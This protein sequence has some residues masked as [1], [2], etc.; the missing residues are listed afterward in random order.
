M[1]LLLT[2]CPITH[3]NNVKTKF[4]LKK[5]ADSF[6]SAH[7]R[8]QVYWLDSSFQWSKKDQIERNIYHCSK[9]NHQS[10]R[11]ETVTV[12]TELHRITYFNQSGFSAYE[13]SLTYGGTLALLSGFSFI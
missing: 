9:S 11:L 8:I 3:R 2:C 6:S 1:L 7:V 4:N 13:K 12:L 5:V 10:A